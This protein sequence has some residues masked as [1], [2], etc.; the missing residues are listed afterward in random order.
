M[1]LKIEAARAALQE[2]RS[3]MSLGLGTGST[4]NEFSVDES[5]FD[6]V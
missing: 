1:N 5:D 4:A 6:P 2:V 3:G